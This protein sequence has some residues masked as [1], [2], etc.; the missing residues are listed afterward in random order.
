MTSIRPITLTWADLKSEVAEM[1][2][3]AMHWQSPHPAAVLTAAAVSWN[4]TWEDAHRQRFSGFVATFAGPSLL[5]DAAG[6]SK[7]LEGAT[8]SSPV[9]PVWRIDPMQFM[10]TSPDTFAR[11]RLPSM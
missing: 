1:I 4:A 8:G 11:L 7:P 9:G 2:A 6:G 10:S 5:R 3:G